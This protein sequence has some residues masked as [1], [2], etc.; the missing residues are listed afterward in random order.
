MVERL[1]GAL[2]QAGA[3]LARP[4][5]F[6]ERALLSGRMDLVEAEAVRELIEA[7]TE[8]AAAVSARRLAGA[9]SARL[10]GVRES[11][12][13]AA[14]SLTAT[15]DFSE[16]VGES[17]DPGVLASLDKAARDLE[18]LAA[19]YRTGRLLSSG[20]RVVLLGR[21][22]V[23]KSTL[24]NALV[25]SARAIVTDVPGTTRDALD[26]T[27]D[28]AGIPVTVVDTAGLRP[29]TD[30]VEAI[31]VARAL[32]EAQKADAV[33]YVVD[34][35]SGLDLEDETTL[36]RLQDKIILFVINKIDTVQPE[37]MPPPGA[38]PVCGL[39][40]DAADILQAA[41]IERLTEGVSLEASDEVLGNVRQRDLVLR[42]A[43]D[44]ESARDALC[45]SDSPEYAATHVDA[46]LSALADVF[47]E[48]TSD[49]VLE[50]IFSTF[51]IGK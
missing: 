17:V 37:W 27:L 15:I 43:R 3:R 1:L 30:A 50:R 5:E 9:L 13:S 10:S 33:L 34:A 20:C 36:A 4:G 45:R 25:G 28:L 31:G 11:L 48:T 18:R 39:S 29:T 14:A 6:T 40:Q 16:D 35:A 49:E 42:A 19:S 44:A 47:G 26:A 7:R 38:L 12:L 41:M 46:A 21:P 23:G 2:T 24:F 32:E 22:N 51:C 8:R